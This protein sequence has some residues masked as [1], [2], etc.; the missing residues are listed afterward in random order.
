M[1][2]VFVMRYMFFE[3]LQ[4]LSQWKWIIFIVLNYH[5]D[6]YISVRRIY[7]FGSTLF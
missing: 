3:S 5:L 4:Y 7:V 6:V 2:P 1:L